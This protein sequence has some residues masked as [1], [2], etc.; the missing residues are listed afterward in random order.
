[1]PSDEA[2]RGPFSDLDP[3]AFRRY[4]QDI[5]DWIAGFLESPERYPVLARVK[6]G[7]IR[8][9]LPTTAPDGPEPL[10]RILADVERIIG[11]TGL[12]ERLLEAVNASGEAFLSHV[13]LAGRYAL[14][15]AIDNIRTEERHV[16]RA[17]EILL[18]EAFCLGALPTHVARRTQGAS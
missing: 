6:P 1:M 12:N 10:D 13:V 4:G 16:Q 3:E 8:D 2:A 15:L 11:F 9:A 5:V 17:R 14:R 18:A 7:D